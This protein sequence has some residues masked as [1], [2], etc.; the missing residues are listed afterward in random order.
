MRPIPVARRCTRQAPP[1]VAVKQ[2][3]SMVFSG[4]SGCPKTERIKRQGIQPPVRRVGLLSY[5]EAAGIVPH[6]PTPSPRLEGFANLLVP[7]QPGRVG[8]D[9][10]ID[11]ELADIYLGAGVLLP[12]R[13]FVEVS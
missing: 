8:C 5:R 1:S 11:A 12:A 3:R 4:A 2:G 7:A 6:R 10:A 13:Q 9:R